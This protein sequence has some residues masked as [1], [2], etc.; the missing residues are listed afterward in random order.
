M[1]ALEASL[2]AC[3]EWKRGLKQYQ[4]LMEKLRKLYVPSSNERT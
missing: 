2:Q 4:I 3:D 1:K